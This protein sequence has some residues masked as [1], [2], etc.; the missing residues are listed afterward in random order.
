M[1]MEIVI[2]VLI[3]LV[4]GIVSWLRMKFDRW[5][6]GNSKIAK[7]QEKI[8]KEMQKQNRNERNG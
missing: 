3:I 6:T 5:A 2:V 8:L 7:N 4:F 1:E